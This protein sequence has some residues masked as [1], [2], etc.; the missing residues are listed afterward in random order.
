MMQ[1]DRRPC[2]DE[3][4]KLLVR[5]NTPRVMTDNASCVNATRVMIDSARKDE[6]LLEAV[7]V[8]TDLNLCIKK[9]YVSSDGRWNMDVFHVT[10]LDG[11]KLTDNSII[12]CIEQSLSVHNTRSNPIDGTTALELTGTDRVGLLSEIFAVLSYLKCD[13]VESKVWTHNGRVASL[14]YLKDMDTG[15]PIEDAK[16]INTIRARLRNVLKGDINIRSAKTSVAVTHTERRLHQMMFADRDY[17]RNSVLKKDVGSLPIVSVQNCLDKGYSVLNIQSK[18]R[19]KLLFDVVCSL[20]DMHY[21]I[22]H[23]T[24]NTTE[25]GAHLEFFIK[26]MDGTPINSEAEKERVVLCLSA[27]IERRATEGVRLELCKADKP[28][29]LAEVM[30]IFRENA[31]NVIRADISTTVGM[32]HNMF[33]VTD[34]SGNRV[35]SKVIDS[36]QQRIGMVELRVKESHHHQKIDH[37]EHYANS[38]GGAVLVSLGSLLR[39]NLY[40]LGLIKSYS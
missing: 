19:P 26:H 13:V 35:D 4:E 29:L 15:C 40:N 21:V 8:L 9:G 24:I 34:A 23:A 32:A 22:F 30:R 20:T 7:Q 31:L 17:A 39:R 14:I 10:D 12:N 27:A 3:Y 6:I 16:K 11:N 38:L 1:M 37:Q 36:V 2:L 5:M 18:D 25:E 28:G 33:Y